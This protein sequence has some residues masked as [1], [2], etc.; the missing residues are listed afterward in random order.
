M[1]LL[2]LDQFI[3][4]RQDRQLSYLHHTQLNEILSDVPDKETKTTH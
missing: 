3:L 4:H 1:K 2:A